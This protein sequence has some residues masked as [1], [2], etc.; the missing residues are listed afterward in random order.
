MRSGVPKCTS[1]W[2]PNAKHPP[3]NAP[4]SG[5]SRTVPLRLGGERAACRRM[6]RLKSE[7]RA[8][9]HDGAAKRLRILAVTAE[10]LCGETNSMGG[11]PTCDD[12]KLGRERS[13]LDIL[14][15]E[16]DSARPL[17][18]PAPLSGLR[19]LLLWGPV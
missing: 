17:L 16:R 11:V 5:G 19:P 2:T 7:K 13:A 10:R 15:N 3:V 6:R 9:E 18:M 4:A 8:I 12:G 14:D 1:M